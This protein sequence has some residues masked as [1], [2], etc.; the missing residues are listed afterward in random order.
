V[1]L[2]LANSQGDTEELDGFIA[3][4][5]RLSGGTMQIDVTNKWRWGQP[6]YDNGLIGDVRAGKSDLGAAAADAWDSVGV[7]SF[8]ALGA[9]LLIN[10]YALQ[11]KVLDGPMAAQMLGGLARLGL[12]GLTILPG[13]LRYPLGVGRPLL[14]PSS[15][16]GLTIG[17]QQS[18]VA[19]ATFRALGATPVW[20]AAGASIHGLGGMDQ[21]IVLTVGNRYDLVARYLTANSVLWPRPLVLFANPKALARLTRSQLRTLL[22]AAKL[23]VP[24]QTQYLIDTDRI[25]TATLCR[26]NSMELVTATPADL[27]ALERAVQPVYASLEHNAETRR[28]MAELEDIRKS[29]APQPAP[30]CGRPAP[31]QG[32][33]SAL[34]GVYQQTITYANMEKAH[35]QQSELV[36]DN[37]GLYT[38]VFDRGRFAFTQYYPAGHACTNGYGWLLIKGHTLTELF[39][40]GGG[41]AP[42]GATNKP[43][44]EFTFDWSFYRGILTMR[45]P[46][47]VQIGAQPTADF[48]A[49]YRLISKTPSWRYLAKGCLP[50]ADALPG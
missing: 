15:Y 45:D 27:S 36:P 26:A 21:G 16:K 50:P 19:S 35:A 42:T 3:E 31:S 46:K 7:T 33:V 12:V 37:M 38:W 47:G 13:P 4:V 2:T 40:N 8:R 49:P 24:M 18:L 22:E 1:V 5:S 29:F 41:I 34:D 48:A 32:A 23:D 14:G 30:T 20:V 17:V 10:S 6:D 11:E 39:N 43:G 28:Q 44:E 9:P 25:S